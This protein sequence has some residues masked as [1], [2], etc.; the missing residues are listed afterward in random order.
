MPRKKQVRQ[1]PRK[2]RLMAQK[3][4]SNTAVRQLKDARSGASSFRTIKSGGQVPMKQQFLKPV[5]TSKLKARSFLRGNTAFSSSRE[6]SRAPLS[7]IAKPGS[8]EPSM[9]KVKM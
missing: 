9:M 1:K 6:R 4:P 5:R 3:S 2:E 8:G 7:S